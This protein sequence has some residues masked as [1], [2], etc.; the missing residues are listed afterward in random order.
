MA[1]WGIQLLP[2]GSSSL[3]FAAK[4]PRFE[5]WNGPTV[6]NNT[7]YKKQ[8]NKKA[9]PKHCNGFEPSMREKARAP[10]RTGEIR[11]AHRGGAVTPLA[12]CQRVRSIAFII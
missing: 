10:I 11:I 8:E 12:S 3:D 2:E 6:Y 1:H 9:V 4:P 5:I 7:L